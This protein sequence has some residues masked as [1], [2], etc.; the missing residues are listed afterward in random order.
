MAKR[1]VIP[2]KRNSPIEEILPGLGKIAQP[3]MR[4]VF[5]IPYPVES[6][7]YR[8]TESPTKAMLAGREISHRSS[9]DLQRGLAE[10]KI[11]P[12]RERLDSMQIEVAV[13]VYTGS[14]RKLLAAYKD[15]DETY[16]IMLPPTRSRL[17]RTVVGKVPL[18]GFIKRPSF[19]PVVPL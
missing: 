3:G 12:A 11:A 2:L 15:D 13:H 5:L 4:V 18:L 16:L 14:L 6:W 10:G 8:T 7:S 17:W 1:I 19:S 9:W